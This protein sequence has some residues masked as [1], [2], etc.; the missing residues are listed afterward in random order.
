M[1]ALQR[2]ALLERLEVLLPGDDEQVSDLLEVDLP[3]GAAAEVTKCGPAALGDFDIEDVGEL[4]ADPAG[5]AARRTAPELPALEEDHVHPGFAQ[6][7]G[8]AR[9]DHP[10]ADHD[11]GGGFGEP[12]DWTRHF[13]RS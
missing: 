13:R 10:A 7:K 8:G 6:V 2:H 1:L 3:A 4:G 12:G 5:C 9:A 11:H